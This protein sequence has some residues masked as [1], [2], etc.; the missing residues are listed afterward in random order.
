MLTAFSF[1][2]GLQ[3]L[4]PHLRGASLRGEHSA[5]WVA[6]PVPGSA[7]K[8]GPQDRDQAAQGPGA[9]I[10]RLKCVLCSG[11]ARVGVGGWVLANRG[12]V[13]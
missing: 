3:R 7:H 1:S 10:W 2:A 4:D 12:R 13:S 11:R 9:D 6:A 5:V 8:A